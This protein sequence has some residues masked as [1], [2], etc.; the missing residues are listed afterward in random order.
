MRYPKGD[1]AIL[2]AEVYNDRTYNAS[3]TAQVQAVKKLVKAPTRSAEDGSKK[4]TKAQ[5]V[6]KGG[7]DEEDEE[8]SKKKRPRGRPRVDIKDESQ[9]DKRRTQIRLAQ[10]AYRNRKEEAIQTLEKEVQK[11][12][13]T[14]E[15]MSNAFMSLHDF[16]VN[17]GM[18]G[19]GPEFARMLRSTMEKFVNLARAA[20]GEGEQENGQGGSADEGSEAPSQRGTSRPDA[21]TPTTATDEIAKPQ[22]L[23]GGVVMTQEPVSQA[24]LTTF[25][26]A[27]SQPSTTSVLGYEIVT[28]PTLLN[29]SFPYQTTPEF[30]F[31]DPFQTPGP[32]NP[33]PPPS[34][35]SSQET[36]FGRRLQR[37]ALEKAYILIN[38]PSAPEA[39]I[40]RV[41]GFCLSFETKDSIKR[42]LSR[43]MARNA[44]ETLS[45]WQFPFFHLG[46]AG[47]HY[48]TTRGSTAQKIGNQ[49][50]L[51][52][53]KPN[54]TNGFATGPFDAKIN[55]VRDSTLDSDMRITSVTGFQGEYL[56]CDEVEI[57][58]NE[59]GLVIPSN[60]DFVTVEIDPYQFNNSTTDRS[61]FA[62]P[63][64]DSTFNFSMSVP[65][66]TEAPQT[67]NLYSSS[68]SA[69]S[70]T[71]DGTTSPQQIGQTNSQ[72][73]NPWGSFSGTDSIGLNSLVDPT[74]SDHFP[75][76][77]SSYLDHSTT[78]AN[79][80]SL[81]PAS[82]DATAELSSIFAFSGVQAPTMNA[83]FDPI[84]PPTSRQKVTVNVQRF[85]K[86]M[87]KYARC[88][89][90][91]PGFREEHINS[92]FWS[93]AQVLGS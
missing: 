72:D 32:Y 23:Y 37:Y 86:G 4:R 84:R 45:N 47:T 88:L 25:S 18:A 78:T 79:P 51:D 14:N 75:Q 7:T 42:R 57:Y 35:Y 12:K 34:S 53:L 60:A 68:S 67:S 41:F 15:E 11:L 8:Q 3:L 2:S 85:I 66:T 92:A 77:T 59:R 9:A 6:E 10:R 90:R 93:S 40:N 69:Q 62:M 24:A 71:P 44:Q 91:T 17:S 64:M 22:Q 63:E 70:S 46:G 33:L 54:N 29:A 74:L 87:V 36:T 81:P 28:Q 27:A 56:D 89:G 31:L 48:D 76:T 83:H 39:T 49:G 58:L 5:A 1:L 55:G 43:Q 38:M 13:S 21:S 73:Q 26:S 30:G 82:S 19:Q 80:P 16:A 50:T 61:P 20:T 65:M 52:V